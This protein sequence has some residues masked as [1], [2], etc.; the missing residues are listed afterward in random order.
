MSLVCLLW[1]H[2]PIVSSHF[3]LFSRPVPVPNSRCTFRCCDSADSMVLVTLACFLL[4]R[5]SFSFHFSLSVFSF[6]E[7]IFRCLHLYI[8]HLSKPVKLRSPASGFTTSVAVLFVWKIAYRP[9]SHAFV[10]RFI[11]TRIKCSVTIQK[12]KIASFTPNPNG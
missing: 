12:A 4:N 8:P 10:S 7:T 11:Q 9:P 5:F 3:P 1:T 6:T 2:R